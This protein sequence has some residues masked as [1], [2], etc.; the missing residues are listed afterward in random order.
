MNA[1]VDTSAVL[2]IEFDEAD[3][4]YAIEHIDGASKLISS[5]LMEA[6]LQSAMHRQGVELDPKIIS[7][8][9]WIQPDRPLTPEFRLVLGAGYLRGADLWHVA[10]ALYASPD[11]SQASFITLD[12]RQREVARDIGFQT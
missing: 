1:Y 10:V 4:S 8:V 9:D 7:D 3:S 11:P 2:A 12:V 6:E 5:N